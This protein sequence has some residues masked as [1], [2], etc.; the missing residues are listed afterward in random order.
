M[1]VCAVNLIDIA[2]ASNWTHNYRNPPGKTIN[3]PFSVEESSND[4]TINRQ[5]PGIDKI[6][7]FMEV[8]L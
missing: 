6:A 1:E 5:K 7:A 4:S 3:F 8:Q 2:V